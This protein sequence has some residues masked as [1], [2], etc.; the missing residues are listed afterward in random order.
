MSLI[1]CHMHMWGPVSFENLMQSMEANKLKAMNILS[2]TCFGGY[3]INN[4][5]ALALLKVLY[6]DKVYGF[7]G[8]EFAPGMPKDQLDFCGQAKRVIEMGMD[9]MKMMDGKPTYQKPFGEQLDSPLYEEYYSYLE[10][11]NIPVTLHAGDPREM[12]EPDKCP[13]WARKR[14]WFYGDGTY[15][16]LDDY[17]RWVENILKRTPKLRMILAH[18]FFMSDDIKRA[19]RFLDQ[20]PSVAFDLT[21]GEMFKDFVKDPDQWR[22]FFIKHQDRIMFGTDNSGGKQPNNPDKARAHK[23]RVDYMRSVLELEKFS[24]NKE[25]LPGMQLP[26]EVLK[27]VYTENFERYA[28]KKPRPVIIP[29][30]LEECERV[31]MA[32]SNISEYEEYV[33]ILEEIQGKLRLHESQE[34][35]VV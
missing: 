30:A 26:T 9:G 10:S 18:F 4:N 6:P 16:A 32:S 1:D 17:Y 24:H 15:A 22:D 29:A 12:W 3:D 33:P 28:G 31:I 21:P 7:G 27:K 35:V 5:I 8:L 11:A 14:G 19:D 13:A 25:V 34:A 20:W 2:A 23:R